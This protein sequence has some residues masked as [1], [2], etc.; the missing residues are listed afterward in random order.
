MRQ[1]VGWPEF[2][3]APALAFHQD[4]EPTISA[5]GDGSRIP[6][7]PIAPNPAIRWMRRTRPLSLDIVSCRSGS[8]PTPPTLSVAG[9]ALQPE[10]EDLRLGPTTLAPC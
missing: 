7:L 10:S 5:K 4:E 6:S 9:F 2:N 1:A 8:A 3:G